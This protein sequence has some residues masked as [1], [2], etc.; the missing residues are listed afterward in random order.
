MSFFSGARRIALMLS[1]LALMASVIVVAPAS[2]VPDEKEKEAPKADEKSD[3]AG[4]EKEPATEKDE[5]DKDDDKGE[6]DKGDEKDGKGDK[7]EDDAKPFRGSSFERIATFSVYTNNA[8]PADETVAEIV[9]HWAKGS[10]LVYTDGEGDKI[11]FVDI[12]DPEN[13]TP[14]GVLDVGGEPTS[15]S[16]FGD[17]AAVG[18]NT[19]E[20]FVNPT[21]VL[22]IVDLG[23]KSIAGEITLGGQPDSVKASPDGKYIAVAIEN[24]RD[25]DIVVD[26]EEG[27]LP[28]APAG[29]LQI[30]DV[31]KNQ[32]PS[33]WNVRDVDL[34]GLA[35]YGGDDPEPE[36]VD[37]N[38]KNKAVVTLQENNHIVIVN[39]ENGKVVRDYDAGTVDLEGIDATEDD[40]ISF[41]ESLDDVPREPDAVTWIGKRRIATANEGDLFGGSRGFTIFNKKGKVR[42]DSGSSFDELAR[43][44][45][46][47]NEGRSENKGSEPESITYAK[48][49]KGQRYLFVGSERGSFVG[50]YKLKGKK[51]VEF[52]QALPTGLGPEGLLAIPEDGLFVVSSEVDDPT[53]GVRA[54]I[55]IYRLTKGAPSYPEV[56]SDGIGWSAMSGMVADESDPDIAY[57]VWDSFYAESKV[58]TLDVSSTPARVIAERPILKD[59]APVGYDPE[60][61][62][63]DGQGGFWIASEGAI[64]NSLNATPN[65]LIHLDAD[66]NV[67]EEITLPAAIT[68]CRAAMVQQAAD[69]ADTSSPEHA[70][71]RN[72]RFGFEGVTVDD[73]GLVHVA[74]QRGWEFDAI[75]ADG[76]A[77]CSVYSTENGSAEGEVGVTKIWTY[78]PAGDRWASTEYELDPRPANASWVG[79]SEITY[80]DGTVVLIERDNRT[81]DWATIKTL[82][83]V[84]VAAFADGII[85]SGEQAVTDILDDLRATNGW[86][87]DKPEGTAITAD[88]QVYVITDNDGVDDWSGETH[89]LRL[90]D[91]DALFS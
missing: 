15:V 70:R 83:R 1:A 34:T 36:F 9:D 24:E 5:S 50:V 8:D 89:F 84:D 46:H 2:A 69:A 64:P 79:L 23:S 29:L 54:T 59:G 33:S 52:H 39:L 10:L 6:S 18:V 21:G 26:G 81:G 63:H 19:S 68:A 4:D 37:V 71:A 38:K 82:T 14:A 58:F 57:A 27:G 25:E 91:V 49:G 45:G 74:Q 67:I 75:P 76:V 40:L 44:I 7:G 43:D 90:G 78:D 61:I 87:S 13:P 65:L 16:V 41:T 12:A 88:G 28:Q 30:V 20:D 72:L 32:D 35:N 53:T 17:Y 73:E 55:M 48:Y 22:V 86:V 80:V 11:G 77:D 62:A 56:V 31:K 3:G 66:L 47:Y 51:G 85:T 42:Y 60:G